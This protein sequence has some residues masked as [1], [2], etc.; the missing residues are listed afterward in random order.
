MSWVIKT[1]TNN[2]HKYHYYDYYACENL[3]TH[4]W[5]QM[6]MMKHIKNEPFSIKCY[7]C[8]KCNSTLGFFKSKD[9][10]FNNIRYDL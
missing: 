2:Y 1:L 10:K 8:L 9:E 6:F 5:N 3:K 4:N 7:Y